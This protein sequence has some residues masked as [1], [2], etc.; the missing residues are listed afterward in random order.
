M[1]IGALLA[2]W[3]GKEISSP[4]IPCRASIGL[5]ISFFCDP[6]R[7]RVSRDFGETML[8]DLV[9]GLAECVENLHSNDD[10]PEPAPWLLVA[11]AVIGFRMR[12]K[13]RKISAPQNLY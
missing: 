5:P 6:S 10:F 12:R 13:A 9:S 2:S 3:F 7:V 1:V 11:M 8:N 4:Q